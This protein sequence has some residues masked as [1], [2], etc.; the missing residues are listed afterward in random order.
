M[1]FRGLLPLLLLAMTGL[2]RADGPQITWWTRYG[3]SRPRG[4]YSRIR[5]A[6]RSRPASTSWARRSMHCKDALKRS[7]PCSGCCRTCRSMTR[8]FGTRSTTTSS[9]TSRGSRGR[10]EA[11][12]AGPGAGQAVA[13]RQG[14]LEHGH[15]PGRAGLRLEDRRLGPAVWPGRAGLV[16]GQTTPHRFRLDVW[17]HGRGE[18]LSE[19]NFING[20][21]IIARRVHAAERVRPASLRP[22]LQRQQVC[23]RDRPVRGARG[24]QEALPDRRRSPGDAGLLD[25]RRRLLAVRRPLSQLRGSPP[26]PGAGFSET[27]DFLKVFQ[28]ETVQPTWYEKKLWHLYDCTDY[29][30][31][32]FNCPTVAYSGEDDRQKQ[33]ADMMAKALAREGIELVHVIG[34]KAGH[35][36]TPEAKAEIN[37]RIDSIVR[38]RPRPGARQGSLHHL[39]A[40]LQ[41]LVLGPGRRPGTALGAGPRRRRLFGRDGLG[42]RGQDEE[43]LGLDA[44]DSSR[45]LPARTADTKPSMTIDGEKVEAP[46]PLSDR[47]WTAHFRKVDGHWQSVDSD[48]DGTLR[49]RHGLQGP[50][51]D[52]FMD[53]FL[54]VRPTGTALNDEGRQWAAAEMKHAID[55]WRR[56]FRGEARVKDDK[57]ITDADIAA[58]NLILWGDPEQQRHAGEDR[59]QAADASGTRTACGSATR[60]IDAGHHVPVLIYPNPLNPKR[61]VVLNS[62]FTFREYD[63]LNNARQVPKLPDFAVVDID[64]PVSSR[65]PGGIVTAGFFN[66]AWGLPPE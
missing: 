8:P 33:A 46:E 63:Y 28:N 48:D 21:Q 54:M 4:S 55:H 9:S 3:R 16:P 62:G 50:I 6:P 15:R 1:S 44:G 65:S 35:Q 60:S 64:V 40:P 38:R 47:S 53:S 42:A 5:I 24:H 56:Q 59:R 34:A 58:H 10:E 22:L 31:N 43:C 17:C 12:R 57:D 66:E 23:R 39:D 27:A 20:R 45:P 18:N 41:P 11:A 36:Y 29:A 37:R 19:V 13:R 49:K 32:L 25:G 51:D 7:P 30:L 52:A 14:T 61:Y 26:R 2:V